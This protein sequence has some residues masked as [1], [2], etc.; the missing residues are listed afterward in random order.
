LW[1][2]CCNDIKVP[3]WERD[4]VGGIREGCSIACP[5]TLT[6]CWSWDPT[7]LSNVLVNGKQ[8]LWGKASRNREADYSTTP[9]QRSLRVPFND[10]RLFLTQPPICSMWSVC[11]AVVWITSTYVLLRSV[12]K[13]DI[14]CMSKDTHGDVQGCLWKLLK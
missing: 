5:P 7:V 1:S 3:V 12:F 13:P 4:I 14:Y 2:G 8:P 6:P 10:F 9:L 11:G